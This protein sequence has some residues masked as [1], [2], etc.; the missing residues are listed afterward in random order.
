MNATR[1]TCIPDTELDRIIFQVARHRGQATGTGCIP[2]TGGRDRYGYGRVTLRNL[3]D[4]KQVDTG[5][6]RVFWVIERGPIIDKSAVIDHLCR[7][8]AC[9]NTDH[10]ELVSDR[11]NTMRGA[12]P[13]Q[14]RAR[15]GLP[16]P[17]QNRP[18]S[19]KERTHCSN[20]HEWVSENIYERV[21]KEGYV[22]RT[23][24]ICARERSMKWK[25]RRVA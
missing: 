22:R 9:V 25:A 17:R 14:N 5:A 12:I 11:T 6:H 20:G 16:V 19:R 10:M 8:R 15:L 21:T 2:W 4:I 18:R 7:N 23:C 3:G 24:K 1:F 13:L